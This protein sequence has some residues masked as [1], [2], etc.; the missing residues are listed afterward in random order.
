MCYPPSTFM[1]ENIHPKLHAIT[2]TCACGHAMKTNSTLPKD[3]T[4]EICSH[5]H[6]YFTGKQK[7]V[8]TAGKVEKFQKKYGAWNAQNAA[9]KEKAAATSTKH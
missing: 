7:L 9:K 6:P 4:V 3:F 8:D 5:C 1:K 2:V